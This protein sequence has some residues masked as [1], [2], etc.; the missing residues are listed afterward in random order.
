MEAIKPCFEKLATVENIRALQH[1]FSTDYNG[2]FNS[3]I[4]AVD[5]KSTYN[6]MPAV[7]FAADLA[8][9][10]HN[11]VWELTTEMIYPGMEMKLLEKRV[12]QDQKQDEC[13]RVCFDKRAIKRIQ[14]AE[15]GQD[16]AN[17]D[18][19]AVQ[20]LLFEQKTAKTKKCKPA[21]KKKR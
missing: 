1:D 6:G 8:T 4:W 11:L 2:A 12:L 13:R 9:L 18:H 20:Q 5:S 21:K 17:K 7:Q 16:R 14:K 3:T 19:D 10:R 15:L